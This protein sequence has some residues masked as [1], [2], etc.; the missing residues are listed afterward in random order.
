MATFVIQIKA[1]CLHVPCMMVTLVIS[2]EM[3]LR[4]PDVI[5]VCSVTQFIPSL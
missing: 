1:K 5:A 2:K 4:T 3:D